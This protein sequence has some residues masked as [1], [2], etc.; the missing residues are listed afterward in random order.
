MLLGR[1]VSLFPDSKKNNVAVLNKFLANAIKRKK[2]KAKKEKNPYKVLLSFVLCK[3][4]NMVVLLH[5]RNSGISFKIDS[6]FGQ[7]PQPF[8][9][10]LSSNSHLPA[11]LECTG[12]SYTPD[13]T[14]SNGLGL[15]LSGPCS[16]EVGGWSFI[17]GIHLSRCGFPLATALWCGGRHCNTL[18]GM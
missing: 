16:R 9:L 2:K 11:N 7:M 12:H 1:G 17:K 6:G 13:D 8:W 4:K 10:Q 15:Q 5:R 14:L 3:M 18:A